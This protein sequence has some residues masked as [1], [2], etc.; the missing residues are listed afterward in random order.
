[1]RK[2]LHDNPW[3]WIV[4]PFLCMLGGLACVVVIAEKNKPKTV[5]LDQ[6]VVIENAP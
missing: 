1:M 6:P 4:L 2:F 5:P 3:I